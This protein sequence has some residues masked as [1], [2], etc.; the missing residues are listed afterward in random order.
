MGWSK[1]NGCFNIGNNFHHQYHLLSQDKGTIDCQLPLG[2]QIL[3]LFSLPKALPTLNLPQF[4]I[5]PKL[6]RAVIKL[7][8]ADARLRRA[9]CRRLDKSCV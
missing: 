6:A 7:S 3:I 8:K 2:P 9:T 4:S 1:N 5:T